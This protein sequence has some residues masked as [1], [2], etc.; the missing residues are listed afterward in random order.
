MPGGI[1]EHPAATSE[2][3]ASESMLF[4]VADFIRLLF[5]ANAELP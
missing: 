4:N 1:V 5:F 3:A 2:I